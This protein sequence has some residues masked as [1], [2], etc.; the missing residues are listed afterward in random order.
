MVKVG[1]WVRV[2]YPAYAKGTRGYIEAQEEE[3][4]RWIVRLEENPT[5]DS[6]EPLL[7]S[8]KESEFEVLG[9]HFA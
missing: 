7:L 6:A 4:G 9:S 8:L 2:L 5:R 3:S 1:S